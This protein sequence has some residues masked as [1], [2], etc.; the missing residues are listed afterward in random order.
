MQARK[1]VEALRKERADTEAYSGVTRREIR[2]MSKADQERWAA[3]VKKLM[4]N[5]DGP[6]TSEWFRIAGCVQDRTHRHTHRAR[7]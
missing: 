2:G 4:E 3:A 6:G 7:P 5:K 1:E